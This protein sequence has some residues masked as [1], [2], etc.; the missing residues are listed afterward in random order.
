MESIT[1]Q[2][3][4]LN[5]YQDEE[6]YE[7]RNGPIAIFWNHLGDLS[8]TLIDPEVFH[9]DHSWPASDFNSDVIFTLI[10]P[11]GIFNPT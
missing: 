5:N 2:T 6:S 7:A 11:E 10:R 9:P 8:P 4:C 3:K 1:V